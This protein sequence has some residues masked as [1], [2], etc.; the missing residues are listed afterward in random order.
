MSKYA[1]EIRINGGN[2]SSLQ[3]TFC[4]PICNYMAVHQRSNLPT[5][6]IIYC[7]QSLSKDDFDMI[8]LLQIDQPGRFLSVFL[9]KF[10]T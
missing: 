9:Y 6:K 4:L 2:L 8:N 3:L 5:V 1:A 7:L 10:N